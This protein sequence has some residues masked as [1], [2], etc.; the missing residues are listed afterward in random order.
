MSRIRLIITSTL[1]VVFVAQSSI[2]LDNPLKSF[3]PP[4]KKSTPAFRHP[5]AAQKQ[6]KNEKFLGLPTPGTLFEKAEEQTRKSW[7]GMK[8]FSKSLNPFP[9]EKAKSKSKTKKTTWVD[10]LFPKEP[11]DNG[12]ATMGEFLN[13]KR[14][15]F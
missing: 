5:F 1:V 15:G 13:M 4:K 14:P 11:V 6:K 8:S 12:P 10:R 9:Q 2:A 7:S 3:F